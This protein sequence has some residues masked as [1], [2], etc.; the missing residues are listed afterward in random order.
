MLSNGYTSV[1]PHMEVRSSLVAI[2]PS[3]SLV[4]ICAC[5]LTEAFVKSFCPTRIGPETVQRGGQHA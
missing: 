3:A 4:T 1:S 2:N 5:K